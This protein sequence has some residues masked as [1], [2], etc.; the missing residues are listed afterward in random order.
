MNIVTIDPSLSSTAM[1]V[2]DKKF[3]YTKQSIARTKKLNLNRWFSVVDDL[4]TIREFGDTP[5]LPY[6][7]LEAFKLSKF[8]DMTSIIVKDVLDNIDHEWQTTIMMEGYSFSSDAGPLI[9]LT[10]FGTLLRS[11]LVAAKLK[12]SGLPFNIIAPTALKAA[13]AKLTYPGVAKNKKGDLEYRNKEGVAGGSF[14]KHEMYKVLTEN[15]SLDCEWVRM[16]REHSDDILSM[17]S[18]PKPIED[19]NDAKVMYEI[20]KAGFVQ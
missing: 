12:H 14:K 20:V 18:I 8:D 7:E 2:N 4:I 11:K 16:L 17:K 9:D 6:D 1:I 5:D 3:I 10:T 13:A 15:T 19:I